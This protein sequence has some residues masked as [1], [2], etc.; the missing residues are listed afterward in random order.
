[1][2]ERIELPLM[3]TGDDG[4]KNNSGT[5]APIAAPAP[6]APQEPTTTE[7]QAQITALRAQLSE[8]ESRRGEL[9]QTARVKQAVQDANR[10]AQPSSAAADE[11]RRN[12][13]IRATGGNA[14]WYALPADE[15]LKAQGEAPASADEVE[16]A[17]KL[18]GP[19][20]NSLEATQL[21][22]HNYGRYCRLK[23]VWNE[24]RPVRG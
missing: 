10:P 4:Q 14:R 1:V 11:I 22:R 17:K 7:L 5:P 19:G 3:P 24:Y 13:A 2:A 6:T 16:Q 8:S 21:N 12:A 9:E 18:F 20:A 23:K 15:R